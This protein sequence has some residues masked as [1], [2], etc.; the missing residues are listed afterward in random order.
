[1]N[2]AQQ[3]ESIFQPRRTRRLEKPIH[4]M[5]HTVKTV[6]IVFA[7][8]PLIV[9]A[10]GCAE[11][12]AQQVKEAR[13]EQVDD[14]SDAQRDAVNNQEGARNDAIKGAADAHENNVTAADRVDAKPTK[15]LVGV[16][17]DRALYQSDAQA[18]LDKLGV[19][20]NAAQQKLV[21]LGARAPTSLHTQLDTAVEEH[22]ILK[23]QID[24]LG[25]TSPDSWDHTTKSI[26]QQLSA[27]DDRVT[28]L[29]DSI[30]KV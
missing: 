19:R 12:Q 28:Q 8:W 7:A 25:D 5:E 14:R 6:R 22:A 15:E 2:V 18:K 3:T 21:V 24:K 27:L 29:S 16:E 11:S 20:I 13:L 23:R 4:S 30:G 9:A 1:M 26:D 17:K 10:A